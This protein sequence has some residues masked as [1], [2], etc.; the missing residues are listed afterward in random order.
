MKRSDQKLQFPT[1][2]AGSRPSGDGTGM[3][4][5]WRA[6]HGWDLNEMAG[7]LTNLCTREESK[8]AD[9]ILIELRAHVF[10]DLIGNRPGH[11]RFVRTPFEQGAEHV[12]N[13]RQ[14]DQIGYFNS[15]RARVDSPIR[16]DIRG[17]EPPLR[18]CRSIGLLRPATPRIP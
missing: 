9:K 11:C 10:E 2:Y 14:A 12:G 5:A 8:R 13:R 15:R 3:V 17:G 1:A 6:I 18:A 16:Q 7:I 4:G